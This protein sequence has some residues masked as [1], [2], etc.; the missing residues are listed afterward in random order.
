[1]AHEKNRTEFGVLLDSFIER[2]G[3]SAKDL[4]RVS[5]LSSAAI[6]R[7]R[8][9]D[10]TPDPDSE[11][12]RLLATG[13]AAL[14]H[15]T[16]DEQVVF[17]DLSVSISGLTTSYKTFLANLA[18][19]IA[20]LGASNNEL[21]REL[22]FDPSYISRILA[23][24][25]R[26]ADFQSFVTGVATFAARKC[27]APETSEAVSALVDKNLS[28]LS[29][30]D[31]QAA[32]STWLNTHC[33]TALGNPAGSFLMKLDEFNLGD[34]RKSA[35][36][37]EMRIPSIPFQLP[38]TRTYNGIR[39]MKECEIDFLKATV[40]SKS[41]ADV[42]MY[43]DMPIEEMAA[44]GAFSQKW[45]YGT[46]LLL[47]RGLHLHVIHDM[48]RPSR[49]MMLGLESWIPLYMTGQISPYYF[50][51]APNGVFSH[52][53]K[54][55]GSAAMEGEAIAG[56]QG[57]GRYTLTKNRDEVHYYRK[58]AE[59]MLDK[60]RPLMQI[61]TAAN[62]N[63][64]VAFEENN[65][66]ITG[67]R[68]IIASVPPIGSITPGLLEQMLKRAGIHDAERASIGAFAARRTNQMKALLSANDV[69][70]ALPVMTR[71][72][73]DEHPAVLDLS[74]LFREKTVSYAFEEYVEHLDALRELIA[75]Y[76]RSTLVIV[77]DLPFHNVQIAINEG[78]NVLISKNAGPAVHFIVEHPAMISAF[79]QFSTLIVK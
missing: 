74:G 49:E 15:G 71:E 40:Q 75:T 23:G 9:G 47:K 36:F 45:I 51:S 16:L 6:S 39:E 73:F 19:L 34:F 11:Q 24:Q 65:I 78:C 31:R 76:K 38:T 30:A 56:H 12:L 42:I 35:Q 66:A 54:V 28:P 77:E 50:G 52:I 33:E 18:A 48:H 25:R 32:I 4:A 5:G 64:L 62:A 61:I 8:S 37:D 13:I 29:E 79:E 1:M 44:D 69:V 20:A 55:S 7:Y 58:R 14:S 70:I 26:P 17:K 10:R 59:R 46:A 27:E 60:A 67:K 63:E 57:E 21:A 53:L 72:E 22:S 2:I 68:R 43:S 3:C 41:T